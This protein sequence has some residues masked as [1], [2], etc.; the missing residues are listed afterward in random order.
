MIGAVD[1][2]DM[3]VSCPDMYVKAWNSVGNDLFIY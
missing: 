1:Q 2:S 3:T